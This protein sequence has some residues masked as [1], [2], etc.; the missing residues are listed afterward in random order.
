MKAKVPNFKPNIVIPKAV[1]PSKVLSPTDVAAILGISYEA[2]L[3]FIKNSGVEYMKLGRQ[4]RVTE[5]K[6]WAFLSKDGYIM[7]DLT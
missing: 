6:L 1:V 2:A 4:Y 3:S 5:E 7:V